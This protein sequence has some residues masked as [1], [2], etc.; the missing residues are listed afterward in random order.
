MLW[1]DFDESIHLIV[2]YYRFSFSSYVGSLKI[3]LSSM[4]YVFS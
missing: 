3:E 1:F 4:H 2:L